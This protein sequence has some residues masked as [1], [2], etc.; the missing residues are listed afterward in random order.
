MKWTYNAYYVI[1]MTL[2][3]QRPQQRC[4]KSTQLI[5]RKT[6]AGWSGFRRTE[7]VLKL[8]TANKSEHARAAVLLAAQDR[9]PRIREA[10]GH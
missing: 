5:S 8:A 10:R 6:Q 2:G 1:G 9:E 7:C 4:L 3:D